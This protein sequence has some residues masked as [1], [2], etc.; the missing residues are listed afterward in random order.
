M[1]ILVTGVTGRIGANVACDFLRRGH[2]VRGFHFPGDPQVAKLTDRG[3][4]LI[5]GDLRDGPAVERAVAGAEVI[6]H[7][8][9]AF[10]AGGPFTAEEYFDINVRGTFLILEAALRQGERLRHLI[11]ASTDATVDKYPPGGIREPLVETSLPLSTTAWY[12]YSKVLTEHLVD[13]YVRHH[14]LPATVIRFANVWGA[15]EVL[16]FP[17]FLTRTFR[18]QLAD[19]ADAEAGPARAELEAGLARGAELVVACDRHGRPWKKHN[20]EVRDIVHA[21]DRAVGNSRTFG[22]TY[23]IAS[24]EP[25]TWD[26]IV[27]Y[28]SE[29]TGI[30]FVR[31]N[32]P[33]TPTFYEYD[34]TAAR[35]DFG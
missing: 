2:A 17:Q 16:T 23:Q 12:G 24:R 35:S 27:P 32:L 14:G 18:D 21:L 20:L 4:E 34:L 5:E 1:T 31:V 26:G 11:V 22:R 9:A 6:L 25:F 33:L 13:R 7:L 8:G 30:P 15:G 19:R 10:Q 3:V 29:R 28:I